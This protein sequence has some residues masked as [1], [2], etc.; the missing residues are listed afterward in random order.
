MSTP[1]SPISIRHAT[2]SD[3]AA[4]LLLAVLDGGEPLRGDVLIAQVGDEAQAALDVRS[5]ATISDPFRA[6]DQ[7]VELLRLRARALR[8]EWGFDDRPWL[9]R[10]LA[11][12]PA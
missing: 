11:T 8:R 9:R 5:G 10:R 2:E 4:L 12:R 7:L 1:I 6:T 3:R